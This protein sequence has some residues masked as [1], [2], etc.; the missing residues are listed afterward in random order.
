MEIPA[1]LAADLK[2]LTDA[3]DEPGTDLETLLRTLAADARSTV[4]SFRGLTMRLIIDGYPIT[5]T[6]MD[7]VDVGASLRMPLKALCD[8]EPGSE[9]LLYAD[10]PGAFVDLAADLSY[11]LRLTPDAVILDDDLNP[12]SSPAG[13]GG[14]TEMSHVNQAIGILIDQGHLPRNARTELERLAHQAETTVHAAAEHLIRTTL[15]RPFPD[16]DEPVPPP[17]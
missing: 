11:A 14:L 13:I 7:P 12:A 9:L 15:G 10:K 5:L 8:V 4:D 2:A 16:R 1:A 3:L 6:T 17:G